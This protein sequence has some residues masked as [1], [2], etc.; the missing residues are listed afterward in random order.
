[1]LDRLHNN[2]R[3]IAE[4]LS[5]VTT[6]MGFLASAGSCPDMPCAMKDYILKVL[7]IRKTEFCANVSSWQHVCPNNE[8]INWQTDC[9]TV[10]HFLFSVPC[11]TFCPSGKPL[12]S[13]KHGC[14]HSMEK[15]YYKLLYDASHTAL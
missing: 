14:T 11:S 6:A 8:F 10:V 2:L 12:H 3:H 9:S 5:I 4:A 15:R 1:M 13:R 7:K